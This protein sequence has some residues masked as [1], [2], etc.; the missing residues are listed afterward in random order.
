MRTLLKKLCLFGLL[1]FT[2]LALANCQSRQA[3]EMEQARD[4]GSANESSNT[5]GLQ[6]RAATRE[7]DATALTNEEGIGGSGLDAGMRGATGSDAGYRTGP[8]DAGMIPRTSDAGMTG[9]A[10]GRDAGTAADAGTTARDAG[11][12]RPDAGRRR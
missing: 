3:E 9:A 7:E 8:T 6:E 10:T 2:G 4:E 11:T 12:V 1:T 5:A